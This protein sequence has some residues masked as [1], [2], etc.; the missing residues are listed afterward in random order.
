MTQLE[1]G[2]IILLAVVG[3]WAII[4]LIQLK[5]A[6]IDNKR[7]PFSF[8]EKAKVIAR[9]NGRCVHCDTDHKLAIDHIVPLAK[10]GTNS[11]LNLQLLCENC[12][13]SKGARFSG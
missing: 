6:P 9:Y 8:D 3:M 13:T 10:G 12:N 11:I 7:R 1:I 5:T 4:M 2:L